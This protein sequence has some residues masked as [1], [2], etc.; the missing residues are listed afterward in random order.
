MANA[1]NPPSE[2]E[3]EKLLLESGV[4]LKLLEAEQSFYLDAFGEHLAA[5][6]KWEDLR[7]RDAISLYLV[8]KYHWTLGEIKSLSDDDLKLVLH[9]EYSAWNPSAEIIVAFQTFSKNR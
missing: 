8:K 2:K 6:H 3:T 7:A 4:R 5:K 1:Q 9:E